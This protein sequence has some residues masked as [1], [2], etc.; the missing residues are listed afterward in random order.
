MIFILSALLWAGGLKTAAA[1]ENSLPWI[2]SS[3]M[4]A[5]YVSLSP[6]I[7]DFTRFA[8]GGPDANWY[9]GF[10]NAWIVKLPAAPIGEYA[11]AYIGA[12]IG[13]AKTKPN[14]QKPWLRDVLPG[15]VYIGL[16]STPS[17]G[18]ERSFFLA[19]TADIPLEANAQ[20]ATEGT[21]A[22]E[23]FWAEVPLT[24]V[25]F[26]GPN[27][28]T[29]WSTTK[30]FM[31]ASSSPILAA[32]DFDDA[33]LPREDRA[34]NNRSISGVAPRNA[35]N[36]LETAIHNISPALAIKLVPPVN[37]EVGVTELTVQHLGKKF[38][39]SFSA[40]GENLAE[41]WVEGSKDL[42]D[43]ERISRLRRRPP[44][45]FTIPADRFPTAGFYLRGVARDYSGN[46]GKSEPSASVYIPN[47]AN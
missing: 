3:A 6:N 37:D 28:L 31:S 45:I 25:N 33:S 38:I 27:Y 1:Q 36:S 19:E 17:F 15:K 44:Y 21:G 12:K 41:A 20:S 29:V 22:S 34:W 47:G 18:P 11:R 46:S 16:A 13:R 7:N 32:A 4:T 39:V 10:N 35:A 9:I 30:Y 2:S 23:W 43:W 40:G 5:T 8:D 42:L 26:S 14:S 24:A